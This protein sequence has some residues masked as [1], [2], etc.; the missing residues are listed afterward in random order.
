M[1][2]C[3]LIPLQILFLNKLHRESQL[4][5]NEL[6][7]N[8]FHELYGK[9]S[10]CSWK[11]LSVSR[12]P[13][14]KSQR[15]LQFVERLLFLARFWNE[16]RQQTSIPFQEHQPKHL[17]IFN[18]TLLLIL[19]TLVSFISLSW[20]YVLLVKQPSKTAKMS[21]SDL[22][23]KRN[24]LKTGTLKLEEFFED[25]Q[26]QER[27]GKLNVRSLSR[28]N[29]SKISENVDIDTLNTVVENLAFCEVKDWHRRE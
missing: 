5:F 28:L 2:Y 13:N 25:F 10:F 14:C 11:D 26:F 20:F 21:Y 27:K 22:S 4:C 7:Q 29:L 24:C 8:V 19:N 3:A 23:T 6:L 15:S 18:P 17:Q 9:V 1:L 12:L 16:I